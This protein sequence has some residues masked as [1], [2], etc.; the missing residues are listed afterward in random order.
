[1]VLK[2][3]KPS[4]STIKKG[5]TLRN[6]VSSVTGDGDY[7]TDRFNQFLLQLTMYVPCSQSTM[8]KL[9]N[10]KY[11][12]T[13]KGYL[14]PLKAY[15]EEDY[16]DGVDDPPLLMWV[17]TDVDFSPGVKPLKNNSSPGFPTLVEP[18]QPSNCTC[19]Y[20]KKTTTKSCTFVP[21]FE[22]SPFFCVYVNTTINPD[23][24]LIR[25]KPGNCTSTTTG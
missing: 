24:G 20:G 3:C 19:P 6:A 15:Y 10:V 16:P 2:N 7:W 12:K 25:W 13:S 9:K 11:P 1:V 8:N 18:E 23:A 14:I 4:T 5:V 22:D 21:S 17:V